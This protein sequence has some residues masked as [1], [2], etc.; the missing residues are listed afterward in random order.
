MRRVKFAKNMLKKYPK[1]VWC[2]EIAFYLD[3]VSFVHKR[4]PTGQV[5]AP[6]GLIWR[7]K[8][9]R[10]VQACTSKGSKVGGGGKVSYFMA[11]ISY[12]KAS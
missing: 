10:I 7:Q 11:A 9:E 4:N 12:E 1:N 3:G 6:S 2:N 8:L 5:K